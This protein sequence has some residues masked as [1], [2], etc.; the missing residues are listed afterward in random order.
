M[1]MAICSVTPLLTAIATA[2]TVA[3]QRMIGRVSDAANAPV[4]K[5]SERSPP[6]VS[7][8]GERPSAPFR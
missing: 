2:A 5:S 8:T 3:S 4:P 1:S 7:V 6:A